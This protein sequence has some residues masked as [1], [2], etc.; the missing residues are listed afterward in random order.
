MQS[1]IERERLLK[2]MGDGPV[3]SRLVLWR[4][5]AGLAAIAAVAIIG[6]G[7]P[8]ND[9]ATRARVAAPLADANDASQQPRSQ[10]HRKQVFDERRKRFNSGGGRQ[11]ALSEIAK[12][13]DQLTVN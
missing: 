9:V 6:V 13:S 3:A 10:P 8:V 11:S 1:R 4:C 12:P 7:T 5:A 2:L